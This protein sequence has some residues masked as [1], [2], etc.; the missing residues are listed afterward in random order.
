[1]LERSQDSN[2][3]WSAMYF[4]GSSHGSPLTLGGM[5]CGWPSATYPASQSDEAKVLDQV[6]SNLTERRNSA[7]PIAAVVISPTQ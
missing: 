3:G 2:N 7:A 6:R 1:M 5:I 4:Q